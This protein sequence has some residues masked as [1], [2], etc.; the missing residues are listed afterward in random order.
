MVRIKFPKYSQ[1][2]K[3]SRQPRKVFFLMA[4]LIFFLGVVNIIFSCNLATSG[5]KLRSLKTEIQKLEKNNQDLEKK[6]VDL[7]SYAVLSQR[8]NQLGFVK[9]SSIVYLEGQTSLAMR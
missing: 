3:D 1:I 7:S 6:V 8:A 5:E 4:I 2:P 9:T